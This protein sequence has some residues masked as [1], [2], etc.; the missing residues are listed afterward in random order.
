MTSEQRVLSAYRQLADVSGAL[1]RRGGTYISTDPHH[2]DAK[3]RIASVFI[4]LFI[5]AQQENVDLELEFQK[6]MGHF[7]GGA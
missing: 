1:Q 6:A 3:H 7:E 4:D 5:L 2:R